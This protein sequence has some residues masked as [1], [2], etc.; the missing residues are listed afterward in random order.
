MKSDIAA[1]PEFLAAVKEDE[2][3]YLFGAGISS[4]LTDN[5][6]CSWWQWVNNGIDYLKE[7]DMVCT[8]KESMK[9][10]A[11]TDNLIRIAGEVLAL[12]KAEGTYHNWMQTSFESASITNVA[13]AETLRKLLLPQ[14]VFATTNYDLLLEKVA[15]LKTIS[16]EE[17]QEAFAMLDRRKS[18]AILHLH[19][20]YDSRNGKDNIVADQVQ[21]DAVLGDKG[22]Q[23]I[24]NILGTRT[25]IFV[26]CGQ[27]S[28]DGN[29]SQFIRFA[30]EHLKLEKNY[31]FLYKAGQTPANLPN[32]VI[33][34]PYGDAYAD[35]PLFLEDMA[36]L[37]IKTKLLISPIV[38]LSPYQSISASGDRLQQYHFSMQSIPFCG[39]IEELAALKEFAF[40]DQL[41][42]WWAVTGQAGAGKSR[43]ALEFLRQLP[44]S[45]FGFFLNDAC[46]G[47]D[48]KAFTPFSDTVIVVDYVAGRER[49]IADL[50]YHIQKVFQKTVYRLRVLLLERENERNSASWY[51]KLLQRYGRYDTEELKASEYKD[52]FL[53]IGD[54]DDESVACFIGKVC[55]FHGCD[56]SQETMNALRME[57]AK[58]KELLQFRPLFVQIFVEAWLDN[59]YIMPKYDR[60]EDLLRMVLEREQQRWLEMV[61]GDQECCNALIRLLLRANISGKLSGDNI[62]TYYQADWKY[63]EQFWKKHSFPGRQLEEKKQTVMAAA[64]HNLHTGCYEIKPMYPDLVKEYMFCFYSDEETLPDVLRELWQNA[65]RE[66]STFIIRCRMDFSSEP[67]YE[68]VL[69]IYDANTQNMDVL[70]GRMNLLQKFEINESDDPEVLLDI[71]DNEYSFWKSICLESDDTEMLEKIA[72]IKFWGL[73]LVAKQY[74]GWSYYDLSQMMEVVSEMYRIPG[75][76]GLAILKQYEGQ[77]ISSDLAASGFFAESEAVMRMVDGADSGAP[78]F[79]AYIYMLNQ[80]TRMMN[81]LLEGDISKGVAV[82]EKMVNGCTVKEASQVFMRSCC[83][84]LTFCQADLS[85]MQVERVLKYALHV[86]TRYPKDKSICASAFTCKVLALQYCF[87]SGK[88][89]AEAVCTQ[90]E[91][92]VMDWTLDDF[93]Q[94]K[95]YAEDMGSAWATKEM[96]YLN[97]VENEEEPLTGIIA[98]AQQ[99]LCRNPHLEPVVYTMIQAQ[100]ALYKNVRK[101]PIPKQDVETTFVYVEDNPASETV[102]GAFFA[103]LEE[104]EERKKVRAYL[105]KPLISNA[106]QDELYNPISDGGI[107]QVRQQEALL[108]ELLL[109]SMPEKP[110]RRLT[111][112]VGVNA[113][114]PCG[115]GKKFKKCCRGKG[116]YD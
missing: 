57:Y 77:K 24:Q 87:T 15:G 99:I 61:E 20:V 75:G 90:L 5:H 26:G 111:P 31:F 80:N 88:E 23:F 67:F 25:L 39:R 46:R 2:L 96:L 7:P 27:T 8:L 50:L 112:K 79:S 40:Q 30:A 54:L 102:R 107:P 38:G 1:Y 4:A 16:Y 85:N 59:G 91:N 86:D 6:S 44:S 17:P 108:Q 65:A 106:I 105:T 42:L 72:C 101:A 73:S 14:D 63:V 110:Y 100:R 83:H 94:S 103:M 18:D 58:K 93:A 109:H 43:L 22:A 116:V 28:E 56:I 12:N 69:Q 113:P 47:K 71:V 55:A 81:A 68:H 74:A 19:G 89:T 51:G 114:C 52:S 66:F 10:D 41:F 9:K 92:I 11:S 98:Q 78:E 35:L 64:C 29:I 32:H 48:A 53:N 49:Q 115:S 60:F 36:Q 104:S 3:V 84:M 34:I 70:F 13:L 21:Y 97:F 33:P 62:P 37:R 82:L 45:W 76:Q 95:D